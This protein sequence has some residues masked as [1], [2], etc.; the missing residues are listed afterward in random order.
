MRIIDPYAV[1]LT[2][3]QVFSNCTYTESVMKIN[4]CGRLCY[5]SEA[6]DYDS[7][8]FIE[9]LINNGHESVLEHCSITVIV[10]CDR[11]ISHQIVRHRIGSYSQESQNIKY[12][13]ITYIKPFYMDWNSPEFNNWLA[14]MGVCEKAYLDLLNFMP[15]QR[16]RCVL[17]NS[18]A[19]RIAITYNL[20]EWRHFFKL[21]CSPAAHP[22][23]R[24]IAIPLLLKLKFYMPVF[25]ADIKYDEDF[26]VE[27][28]AKVFVGM[29][30]AQECC[31]WED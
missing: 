9:R 31:W 29:A 3:T 18:T 10:T 25:F 17:P 22:Q 5:R 30:D 21:R 16:A 20:R 8:G 27:H 11:A 6:K 1:I 23:M 2:P 7:V 15:A 24:Q 28:Y 13:G 19:T 4:T 14:V 26:P 12:K